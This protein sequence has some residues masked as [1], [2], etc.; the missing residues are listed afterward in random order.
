MIKNKAPQKE[1]PS[2]LMRLSKESTS[3]ML[4]GIFDGDGTAPK[5]KPRFAIHVRGF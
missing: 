2:R 4:Q 3:A 1:I 5:D